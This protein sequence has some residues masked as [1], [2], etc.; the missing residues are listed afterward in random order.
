[1]TG[2]TTSIHGLITVHTGD[3]RHGATGGMARRTTVGVTHGT[4]VGVT[5]GTT[6]D[7]GEDGTT[8]G[9]IG[10]SG[11]GMTL[12]TMEVIGAW[13]IHGTLTMQD[14]TEDSVLT[15]DTDTVPA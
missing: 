4:M 15:G 11:D 12:G 7:T 10:D 5:H 1:M 9:T 2:E 14:G 13:D 6:A 8:R 3:S